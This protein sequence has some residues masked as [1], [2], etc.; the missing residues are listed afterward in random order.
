MVKIWFPKNSV[1]KIDATGDVTISNST[2][3][4]TAFASATEI[5]EQHK[6]F[7]VNLPIGDVN[8]IDLMGVTS[9][10][11]T[12]YQNAEV[13]ELPAGM[14]EI[15]GT[16]VLPGDELMESEIFGT[17]TAAGGTHTTYEPGQATRTKV[18]ILLNLDDGTDEVSFAARNA[19]LTKYDIS[20]TGADG[21][22]EVSVTFKCLPR[23]FFGP[24]FKD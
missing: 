5:T 18:A 4:D 7:S 20:A 17:G 15:S 22:F 8:K 21:H 16:I 1:I 12:D 19:Y 11:S 13:E 6:G 10:D 14:V 3:L 2:V 23:D 24:Q 9:Q